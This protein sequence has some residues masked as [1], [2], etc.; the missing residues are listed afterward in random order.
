MNALYIVLGVILLILIYVIYVY[1]SS[2][3][4]TLA[5]ILDCSLQSTYVNGTKLSNPSSSNFAYG[6]WIYVRDW[7]TSATGLTNIFY[8]TGSVG[9]SIHV[10]LDNN[11]PNLYVQF[12]PAA[13]GAAFTKRTTPDSTT[14]ANPAILVSSNVPLQKWLYFFVSVD[15]G[16]Y[17]DIYLD[18]KMVKTAV[19]TYPVTGILSNTTTTT[20]TTIPGI[21]IGPFKG[22]I[23]LFNSW[24]YA[25]DPQTVWSNY[26][27]G[28]G[29]TLGT[30]Y[31]VDVNILK[32]DEL[33]SKYKLF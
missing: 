16:T 22:Y 20:D 25:V 10:F 21:V 4:K 1:M 30:S 7:S 13:E 23:S 27:K 5:T 8:R 19:L 18:G 3:A 14:S 28:N 32:N 26:M 9:N 29:S 33:S 11:S 6:A 12:S 17:V 31:G 15:G 24:G 2:A